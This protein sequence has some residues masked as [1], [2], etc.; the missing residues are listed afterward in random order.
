MFLEVFWQKLCIEEITEQ[1]ADLLYILSRLAVVRKELNDYTFVLICN[2]KLHCDSAKRL[3]PP[4]I[5]QHEC[6]MGA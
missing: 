2:N 3:N 6:K 5:K 1:G 4:Y